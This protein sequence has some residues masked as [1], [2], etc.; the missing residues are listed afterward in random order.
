MPTLV[1]LRHGKSDYPAGVAD[2]E[3]PLNAR[4][5][6]EA[7]LVGKL[8]GA[9]VAPSPS[10]DLVLVSSATRAQQT[11]ERVV[12]ALTAS[13]VVIDEALYL[14]EVDTL[15]ERIAAL[16][17]DCDV[18]LMVGHNDGF[19]VTASQLTD[20][21][22]VLKTSTFAVLSSAEPW[23]RWTRGTVDLKGVASAR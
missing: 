3:R 11:W 21:D 16:P 6:R 19:E 13:T 7:A 18:V 15:I 20:E 2:H 1:L 5:E 14:A 10:F 8:I 9:A 12:P 22:V 4:G 17:D 23:A